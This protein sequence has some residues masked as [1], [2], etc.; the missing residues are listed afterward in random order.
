[1]LLVSLFN[2]AA[3]F[4]LAPTPGWALPVIA[5][6][7][8]GW[9]LMVPVVTLLVLDLYPERRGLAS[10]LQAVI[11]STANGIVAGAIAGIALVRAIG[12]SGAV[13]LSGALVVA[14]AVIAFQLVVARRNI[15]R[16][17][18]MVRPMFPSPESPAR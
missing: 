9:A 5:L 12:A 10:S 1:M 16:G 7:A 3:N 15:R 4:V 17:Q 14:L 6:F 18:A 2:V 11:G 13:A 8:F